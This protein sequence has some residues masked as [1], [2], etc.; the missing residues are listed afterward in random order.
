MAGAGDGYTYLRRQGAAFDATA[1]GR[2]GLGD[3]YAQRG[4]SPG[5]WAGAGL[6][7]LG[8]PVAG[9]LVVEEQMRSLFGAGRHP[10]AD[11]LEAEALA[12]GQTS[13]QARAAGALGQ[14]FLVYAPPADGFR[15]R[16]ARAFAAVNAARGQPPGAP[17]PAPERARIRSELAAVLFAKEHGRSPVDARSCRGS[18]PGCPVRRPARWPAT[19]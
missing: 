10:D 14:P 5:R 13:E 19:T 17:L 11:R 7:G 9:D 12:A 16:C 15:A 1:R 6:A 4:E 3:Y 2:D 18:S 8:V